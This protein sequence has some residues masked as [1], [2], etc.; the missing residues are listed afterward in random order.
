MKLDLGHI[1]K[2]IAVSIELTNEEPLF[3]FHELKLKKGEIVFG[4]S[5]QRFHEVKDLLK[6][7][8]KA[9][10]F[11]LHFS[12]KGILDR[13]VK[14]TDDYRHSL[15]LNTNLNQF[16]FS[17]YLE[18][19]MVYSSIIR[20]DVVLPII[21]ML[22]EAGVEVVS[23]ASGP[24]VACPLKSILAK[25]EIVINHTKL[26]FENDLISYHDKS[27][28]YRMSSNLGGDLI[29][30]TQ[31]GAIGVGANFFHQFD[32]LKMPEEELVDVTYYQEAKQK[33]IF[34]RFGAAMVIFFFV[35][36]VGNYLYLNHLN[37]K[38]EHNYGEL[39]GFEDQLGE[40]TFLQEEADRKQKLLNS[41][42][43]L[44]RKFLSYYLMEI[45]NTVPD[46]IALS[47]MSVR[48]VENEIKKRH[49]IEFL[50]QTIWIRGE[51][52]SSDLLSR[53]IDDL[54]ENEWINK[55]DILDYSYVKN[56]GEFELE[57]M[58]L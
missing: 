17:D 24:F 12:G 40:I 1:N 42:G 39:A 21:E 49:K 48:P 34:H 6:K 15:L 36:L 19:E 43:L 5:G 22:K 20:K 54:T 26:H 9:T 41:S 16:Y 7:T 31:L 25:E 8:G 47:M 30:H 10:P 55:V 50:S 46:D 2:I 32:Q 27:D 56:V 18:D 13:S 29:D 14:R 37:S 53:W 23:F 11:V 28:E 52:K 58:I 44:N 3:H 51:S 45:S 35:I 38:I 4:K 33:N 57:L